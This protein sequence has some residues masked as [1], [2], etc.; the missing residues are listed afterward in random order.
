MEAELAKLTPEEREQLL[1][2]LESKEKGALAGQAISAKYVVSPKVLRASK[3]QVQA[4]VEKLEKPCI[5]KTPEQLCIP[6]ET[7]GSF[8]DGC[9]GNVWCGGDEFCGNNNKPYCFYNK[10]RPEFF[11]E[12]SDQAKAALTKGRAVGYNN[13]FFYTGSGD[14]LYSNGQHKY[15]EKDDVCMDDKLLMEYYCYTGHHKGAGDVVVSTV[16]SDVMLCSTSCKDGACL[17]N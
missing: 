15:V 4:M 9:G 17:P 10:C 7:C 11:C 16:V 12:D 14:P 3:T 6:S 2:D 1:K 13:A 5:P 8:K